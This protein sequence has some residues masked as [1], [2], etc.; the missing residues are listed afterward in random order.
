MTLRSTDWEVLKNYHCEEHV[1]S[2]MGRFCSTRM[3]CCQGTAWQCGLLVG[4][5]LGIESLC[6]PV[7]FTGGCNYACRV[8]TENLSK[9]RVLFQFINVSFSYSAHT[10]SHILLAQGKWPEEKL[11]ASGCSL[12]CMQT[13]EIHGLGRFRLWTLTLQTW[14]SASSSCRCHWPQP[15]L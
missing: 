15:G 2:A 13:S 4:G 6:C 14:F 10:C 11:L 9:N 7:W 12:S 5:R 8:S 1:P 3:A